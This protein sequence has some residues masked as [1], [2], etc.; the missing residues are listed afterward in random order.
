MMSF[1][2][3]SAP[4]ISCRIVISKHPGSIEGNAL[5]FMIVWGIE[6]HCGM[7]VHF[8]CQKGYCKWILCIRLVRSSWRTQ[9][10]L[11]IPG[12]IKKLSCGLKSPALLHLRRSSNF[13]RVVIVETGQ[14]ESASSS[15]VHEYLRISPEA[16]YKLF[17]F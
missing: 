7:V 13:G 3:G 9:E 4:S 15:L 2:A 6:N 16:M 14:Q 5:I 12:K 1:H 10:G 8:R 11:S 17:V